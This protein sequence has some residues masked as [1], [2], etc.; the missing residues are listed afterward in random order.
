M[1]WAADKDII[2]I[3][4]EHV[5]LKA[6]YDLEKMGKKVFPQPHVLSTIKDKGL[7]KLFY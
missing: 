4:I 5:N 2:T 6:L 7:Q 3:E 1:Q